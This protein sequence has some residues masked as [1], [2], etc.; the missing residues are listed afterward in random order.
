MIDFVESSLECSE[1][2]GSGKV[3]YEGE[4]YVGLGSASGLIDCEACEGK[5][6]HLVLLEVGDEN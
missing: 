1:C 5:G 2:N 6:K 4:G 3:F